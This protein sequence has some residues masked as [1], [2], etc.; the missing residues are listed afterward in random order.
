MRQENFTRWIENIYATQENEI[1]CPQFQ[2]YLPAFV[3]AEL[4]NTRLPHTAV[5][6][7]HLQQCPDCN[8]VYKGLRLVTLAE[9]SEI[10]QSN[11]TEFSPLPTGD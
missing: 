6:D 8:E 4:N 9:S 10:F 7:S 2:N 1:D 5:L 11:S 3:E